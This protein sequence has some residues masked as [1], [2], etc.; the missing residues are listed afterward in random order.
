M[1]IGGPKITLLASDHPQMAHRTTSGPFFTL[2]P[3][4][5][6]PPYTPLTS[7]KFKKR[8]GGSQKL[9]FLA[10]LMLDFSRGGSWPAL[11]HYQDE[12]K[13]H[14]TLAG[15]IASRYR[16][17]AE[18]LSWP[19]PVQRF[20]HWIQTQGWW[21]VGQDKAFRQRTLKQVREVGLEVVLRI[22]PIDKRRLG[23]GLVQMYPHRTVWARSLLSM[24]PVEFQ[25]PSSPFCSVALWWRG[26]TAL[27]N[28]RVCS[29]LIDVGRVSSANVSCLQT[30]APG[31]PPWMAETFQFV[32]K[33]PEL[34]PPGVPVK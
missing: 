8:K 16:S 12:K 19:D 30:H 5:L 33:H 6:W 2:N 14:R 27:S 18:A 32:A 10:P 1:N 3:L 34:V 13:P 24:L 26:L 29:S 28:R 21:S 4:C 11:G 7:C 23:L 17:K 25:S 9:A 31:L 20:G 22:C 15:N